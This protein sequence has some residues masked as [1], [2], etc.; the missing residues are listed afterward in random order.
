MYSATAN[1]ARAR[2]LNACRWYIS[3]FR[4]AKN[5]SAAA[6]SQHTPVRPRLRRMRFLAVNEVFSPEIHSRLK[7][8]VGVAGQGFS[9]SSATSARL[10]GASSSESAVGTSLVQGP[11]LQR[12]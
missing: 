12:C 4:V 9:E 3:F 7:G 2:V 10:R 5:D 1:R 8:A 11:D 6:L